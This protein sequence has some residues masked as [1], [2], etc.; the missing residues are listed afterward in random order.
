VVPVFFFF[1]IVVQILEIFHPR[2]LSML[3][4]KWKRP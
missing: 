1:F 4:P 3:V 2:G